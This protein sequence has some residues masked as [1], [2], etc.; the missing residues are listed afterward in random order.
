MFP[1]PS[2]L[3][4]ARYQNVFH[5]MYYLMYFIRAPL[6]GYVCIYSAQILDIFKDKKFDLSLI[7]V[8][9]GLAHLLF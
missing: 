6:E 5:F 3:S 4:T 2:T 8:S 1:N 7:V 9:F